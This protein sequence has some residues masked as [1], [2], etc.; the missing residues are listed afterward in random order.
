LLQESRFPYPLNAQPDKAAFYGFLYISHIAAK[1]I[2][3]ANWGSCLVDSCSCSIKRWGR[4]GKGSSGSDADLI[5]FHG[6]NPVLV[7]SVLSGFASSLCLWAY[8]M[9]PVITNAVGGILVG[10]VTAHA[11]GVRKASRILRNFVF[12]IVS[13]LLVTAL[14]QFI[15]DGKP[16]S[17]YCLLAL[18]LV[19]SSISIYQKYPYKIKK[20]DAIIEFVDPRALPKALAMNGHKL[21]DKPLTVEEF[22]PNHLDTCGGRSPYGVSICPFRYLFYSDRGWRGAGIGKRGSPYHFPSV[23]YVE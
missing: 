1:A 19:I 5:L 3:S 11:G 18:P 14:L 15:F 20:K 8:F 17:V 2:S 21:G 4:Q 12:V 10:L 22:V 6:I 9:I 13:A 7:E 16:P 23:L